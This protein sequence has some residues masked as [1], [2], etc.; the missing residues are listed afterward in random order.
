MPMVFVSCCYGRQPLYFMKFTSIRYREHLI[1]Y[2]LNPISGPCSSS[3][4]TACCITCPRNGT[5][6]FSL[7]SPAISLLKSKVSLYPATPRGLASSSVYVILLSICIPTQA[8]AMSVTVI[9]SLPHCC[10]SLWKHF[11]SVCLVHSSSA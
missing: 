2:S 1:L 3:K 9:L 5:G 11:I 7:I 4:F 10:L 8:I 6:S